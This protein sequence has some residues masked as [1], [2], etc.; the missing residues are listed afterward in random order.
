MPFF[1]SATAATLAKAQMDEIKG[2]DA[3]LRNALALMAAGGEKIKKDHYVHATPTRARFAR[4][5]DRL[6]FP[7]LWRRVRVVSQ[8]DDAVFKAKRAFLD[9]LKKVADAELNAALPAISCSVIYRPRAEARARQAFIRTLQ[10]KDA[11]RDLFSQE[12]TNA[13][14]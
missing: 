10:S 11:C 12:E 13:S 5:A 4:S 7:N 9:D 8:S 14:A 6:F 2:F 1:S 3:A